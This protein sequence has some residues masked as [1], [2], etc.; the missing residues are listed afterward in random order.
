MM[1]LDRRDPSPLTNDCTRANLNGMRRLGWALVLCALFVP[2]RAR[3]APQRPEQ[4]L[5]L[6]EQQLDYGDYEGV[7]AVLGPIAEDGGRS[8]SLRQDRIEALRVYGI[9]SAVLSHVV[10]AQGAFLQMLDEQPDIRFDATRV[11]PE[12]IALLESV[13]ARFPRFRPLD[14]RR[15][16]SLEMKWGTGLIVA[17][18]SVGSVGVVSGLFAIGLSYDVASTFSW[19]RVVPI[20]L[21]TNSLALTAIGVTLLVHGNHL[22]KIGRY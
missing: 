21:V 16:L 17:G 18:G 6:A 11:R 8:L 3:A 2:L 20:V 14:V 4:I 7:V 5:A 1:R 15:P 9:A 12:A 10:A 22:Q 13:R 19:E